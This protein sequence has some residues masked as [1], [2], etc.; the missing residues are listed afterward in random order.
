[1]YFTTVTAQYYCNNS[2]A[3]DTF[4]RWQDEVKEDTAA[5]DDRGEKTARCYCVS[6]MEL[7]MALLPVGGRL[8]RRSSCKFSFGWVNLSLSY[9]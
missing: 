8:K 5:A 6:E 7:E 3:W 1:M 4:S 2:T 9:A